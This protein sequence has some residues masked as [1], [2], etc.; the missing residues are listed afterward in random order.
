MPESDRHSLVVF[1]SLRARLSSKT[2]FGSTDTFKMV[3]DQRKM[4]RAIFFQNAVLFPEILDG[5]S[6]C[7]EIILRIAP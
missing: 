2:G 3:A 4:A 7:P 1:F 6:K 5:I